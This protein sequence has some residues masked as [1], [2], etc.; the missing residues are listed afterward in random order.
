[1]LKIIKN[2]DAAIYE[3]MTEAVKKNG[4]YC[5]CMFTKDEDTRCPCRDFREQ[6]TEGACHCGRFVK[7]EEG[8]EEQTNG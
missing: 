1:M 5:P 7:V 3:E 4:G 6:T 2:P 8:K